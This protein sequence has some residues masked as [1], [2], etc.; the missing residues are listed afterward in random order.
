MQPTPDSTKLDFGIPFPRT[1]S[2]KSPMALYSTPSGQSSAIN[3]SI[4]LMIFLTLN[5]LLHLFDGFQKQRL[6]LGRLI[7][8]LGA[9]LRVLTFS[10]GQSS[11]MAELS[12][13]FQG[14]A[15]H[16]RNQWLRVCKPIIHV[17][18]LM[19]HGAEFGSIEIGRHQR[20]QSLEFVRIEVIL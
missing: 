18:R 10:V 17:R 14:F 7:E 12:R 16:R 11:L 6:D 15:A 9:K 20:V 3:S 5:L 1:S 4:R 2:P 8:L 13:A 19:I